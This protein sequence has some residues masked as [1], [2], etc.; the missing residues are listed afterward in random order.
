MLQS[1][2]ASKRTQLLLI[3]L[4]G[5]TSL[6]PLTAQKRQGNSIRWSVDGDIVSCEYYQLPSFSHVRTYD[7]TKINGVTTAPD[8]RNDAVEVV[9]MQLNGLNLNIPSQ[10]DELIWNFDEYVVGLQVF[11]AHAKGDDTDAT[12]VWRHPWMI[13]GAVALAAA[14][15]LWV[16]VVIVLFLGPVR[17]EP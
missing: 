3:V 15:A 17:N 8:S 9:R 1:L 12:Y 6:L 4:A 10:S 16:L 5:V 13:A 11:M 7:R 14:V 2:R